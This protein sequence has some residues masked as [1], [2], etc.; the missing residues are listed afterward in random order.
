ML[1]PPMLVEETHMLECMDCIDQAMGAV[2]HV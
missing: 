2:L 1:A